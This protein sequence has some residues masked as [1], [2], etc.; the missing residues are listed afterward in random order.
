MAESEGLTSPAAAVMKQGEEEASRS[1]V[2]ASRIACASAAV[3]IRGSFCGAFS[4]S[5]GR[6]TASPCRRDEGTAST[7]P[8][9]PSATRPAGRPP[10]RRCGP[11][12]H[13]TRS[14]RRASFTVA[15]VTSA[16]ADGSTATS[17]A[18]PAGEAAARDKLP[19]VLQPGLAPVQAPDPKELPQI[20]HVVGVRLHRVRRPADV[21]EIGQEPVTGTTAT[22]SSP[23]SVHDRVPEPGTVTG[24]TSIVSSLN[25]V[26]D[27]AG[28]DHGSPLI[29]AGEDARG[30]R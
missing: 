15:A 29:R 19:D 2:H 25:C 28:D 8:A 14:P 26:M 18:R 10:Q 9:R 24:C 20:F 1:R 7:R 11:G 21:G 6:D 12:A 3:R 5:P 4:E 16:A 13:R 23:S 30:G 27:K 22:S 17:P